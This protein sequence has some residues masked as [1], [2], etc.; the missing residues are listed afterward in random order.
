M[1]HQEI[2]HT[3]LGQ[4]HYQLIQIIAGGLEK[5][6]GENVWGWSKTPKSEIMTK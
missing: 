3:N 2:S 4:V 5:R 1:L 6:D